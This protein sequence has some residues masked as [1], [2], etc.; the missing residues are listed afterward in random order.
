MRWI[1]RLGVVEADGRLGE[2][3]ERYHLQRLNEG[4]VCCNQVG[5]ARLV[6]YHNMGA[7]D[8][9]TMEMTVVDITPTIQRDEVCA[10]CSQQEPLARETALPKTHVVDS[11]NSPNTRL[12]LLGL[13]HRPINCDRWHA[14]PADV[15]GAVVCVWC[16]GGRGGWG[17]GGELGRR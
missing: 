11:L 2:L 1:G 15:N 5:G 13:C 16:T 17:C 8:T 14:A 9:E 12:Q 4:C 7:L 10:H 3:G 6:E